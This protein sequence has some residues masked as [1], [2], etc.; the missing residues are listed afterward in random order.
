MDIN[1]AMRT[2]RPKKAPSERHDDDMKIPL[3]SEEKAVIQ[4]AAESVGKKP[5]TWARDT[6]LRS[7]KKKTKPQAESGGI[8]PE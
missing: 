7:A 5:T 8:E 1:T 2:G 3:T 6:L 4:A